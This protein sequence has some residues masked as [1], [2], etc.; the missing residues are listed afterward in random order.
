MATKKWVPKAP[1]PSISLTNSLKI[2]DH[3][4]IQHDEDAWIAGILILVSSA[5][6]DIR[7]QERGV[8]KVP[9]SEV[10]KKLELSTDLF[11]V[12]VENLVDLGKTHTCNYSIFL[13]LI[14][15]LIRGTK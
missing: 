1:P 2:G 4:W 8:I 5:T 15:S 13:I 10:A 9:V 14:R 11:D 6:Y 12:E 7:T 3:V